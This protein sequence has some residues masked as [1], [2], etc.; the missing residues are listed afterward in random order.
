MANCNLVKQI[1]TETSRHLL[2]N[3]LRYTTATLDKPNSI[4]TNDKKI[5]NTQNATMLPDRIETLTS[6]PRN[7]PPQWMEKTHVITQVSEIAMTIK[8]NLAIE[9][10]TYSNLLTSNLTF[11]HLIHKIS[12]LYNKL[13]WSSSR[14][15][16]NMGNSNKLL[17][18]V[19]Q[20]LHYHIQHHSLHQKLV[21][22]WTKIF[23][24]LIWTLSL[25]FTINNMIPNMINDYTRISWFYKFYWT[26]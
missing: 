3:S 12:K 6:T 10:L 11:N 1:T 5:S 22:G 9:C 24:N 17:S 26:D 16:T 21:M 7:H 8:W 4:A 20:F 15:T 23:N 18:T 2:S 13:Y 19:A 14:G 25:I